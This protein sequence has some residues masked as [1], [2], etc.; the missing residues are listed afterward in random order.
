MHHKAKWNTN[1]ENALK[2][3]NKPTLVSLCD[4]LI[5]EL[6]SSECSYTEIEIVLILRQLRSGRHFEQLLRVANQYL[7]FQ[8]DLL[9]IRLLLIQSLIDL[10]HQFIAIQQISLILNKK[11]CLGKEYQELMG[12][13]GRANKQLFLSSTDDNPKRRQ[14]FMRALKAYWSIYEKYKKCTWHGINTATMLLMANRENIKLDKPFNDLESDKIVKDVLQFLKYKSLQD[15]LNKWDYATYFEAYLCLNDYENAAIWLTKYLNEKVELFDLK[16]TFRQVTEM[17]LL[18][19]N[20]PNHQALL[21]MIKKSILEKQGGS[22]KLFIN[23]DETFGFEKVFGAEKYKSLSWMKTLMERSLIVMK[24][25]SKSSGESIGTGFVMVGHAF[26]PCLGEKFYL[27]T[28]SHVISE[29]NDGD[30]QAYW[31]PNQVYASFE[32]HPGEYDVTQIWSSPPHQ[33][34]TTL[35]CLDDRIREHLSGLKPTPI[36]QKPSSHNMKRVYIIGHPKGNE[37]AFSIHDNRILDFNERF[38][39]YRA[40]TDEGSSGSPIFNDHWELVGIHHKG[41]FNMKKLSNPL[42]E[43]P[44][45]QGILIHNVIDSISQD[46]HSH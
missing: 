16:S 9:A 17:R 44:A 31:Q 30:Y 5:I 26:H 19:S 8:D 15:D 25:K 18:L 7:C 13:L 14:Y 27:L 2:S 36:S 35:L 24:I 20:K 4:E 38:L 1:F 34:D 3:F 45:N 41:L 39:Q 29:S 28:N 6:N 40:P 23:R 22:V 10:G 43:Y 37:L 21:Y 11:E 42:E 33:L 46:I 12:M 32:G